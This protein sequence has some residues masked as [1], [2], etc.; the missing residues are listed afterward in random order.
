[1]QPQKMRRRRRRKPKPTL[2]FSP[3][4]WTK[5]LYFR[6]LGDTEIGGFGLSAGEDPL[7]IVDVLTVKQRC[8][9][10]TVAF[11][12]TA[13][14]DLFD[15]LVD[16]GIPLERFSR[17]WIHT[18]PGGCPLPSFVDEG[19]FGRVF[20]RSDWSVMA[21]VARGG[22]TYARLSFHVGPGGALVIPVGVDY[23]RSFDGADWDAWKLEYEERVIAE[24]LARRTNPSSLSELRDL[25]AITEWGDNDQPDAG[26]F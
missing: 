15:Q 4:A 12:D 1:M 7:L 3:Y 9:A 25:Y 11:D 14:A 21:I 19:T 23:T 20:G 6:D 5:L 10:I 2:R 17:I 22:A 16:R 24:S 8:T 18:H 26:S 13:V